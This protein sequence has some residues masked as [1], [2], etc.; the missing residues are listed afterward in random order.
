LRE[1]IV[2]GVNMNK[3]KK[4]KILVSI[5]FAIS[6]IVI[7]VLDSINLKGFDWLLW[8]ILTFVTYLI[9]MCNIEDNE[10]NDKGDNNE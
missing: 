5:L 2:N 10:K 8:M 1:E 6:V 9:L 7:L 4:Q 3:Y